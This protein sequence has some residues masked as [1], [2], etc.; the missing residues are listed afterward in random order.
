MLAARLGAAPSPTR[1]SRP[2][3]RPIAGGSS[4]GQYRK[5][6]RASAQVGNEA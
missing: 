1:A 6:C 3:Q 4:G 2:Q 5:A